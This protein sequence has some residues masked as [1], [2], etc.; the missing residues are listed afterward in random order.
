MMKIT[1]TEPA[2]DDLTNIKLYI[3]KDSPYYADVFIQKIFKAIENLS[4]FPM[5][6]RMVPETGKET[7]REIIFQNY[8][9]IYRLDPD[10]IFIL[11]VFHSSRDLSNPDNIQKIQ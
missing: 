11:T 3:K 6:G 2:Q 7:I 10:E 1:I 8:R 4:L 5:I 9:V